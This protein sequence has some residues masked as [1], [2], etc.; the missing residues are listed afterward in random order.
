[1]PSFQLTVAVREEMLDH[2]VYQD[3]Y[4]ASIIA[5]RCC[6]HFSIM[7]LVAHLLD[8]SFQ[9]PY[10]SIQSKPHEPQSNTQI[11]DCSGGETIES[12]SAQT[13]RHA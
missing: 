8:H 4:F 11:R 9:R 12:C 3:L 7:K 5:V 13:Q 6:T 2:I 1:M 10:Q